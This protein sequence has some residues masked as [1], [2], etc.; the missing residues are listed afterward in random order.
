MRA[1]LRALASE[2]GAGQTLPERLQAILDALCRALRIEKGF[3][4]IRA[5]D[6]FV[7][8]AT[9]DAQPV[10]HAFPRAALAETETVGLV[11]PTRKGLQGMTLLIPLFAQGA[12]IGAV[13]LGPREGNVPYPEEDYELLED[14][15]DEMARVIHG[16]A[17]QAENAQQINALVED[18]RERERALQLQ[19]QRMLAERETPAPQPTAGRWDEE[20]LLPLVEDALRQLHDY[21]YLGEHALAQLR[22][23]EARSVSY[24]ARLVRAG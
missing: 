1:N 4:A 24:F 22:V 10:G 21:P 8:R 18:F 2:A 12:Q 23:V 16:V 13:V 11:L 5:Q 7:V 20:K 14:L 3:V 17:V 19:V 9:H 6:A 15:S